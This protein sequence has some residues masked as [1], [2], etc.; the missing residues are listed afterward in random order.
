MQYGIQK[1]KK[2]SKIQESRDIKIINRVA[3]SETS[4][5]CSY[6]LVESS[7]DQDPYPDCIRIQDG[8]M[9]HK[10]RKTLIN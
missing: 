4:T 3:D 9:T 7:V 2:I 5:P 6:K 1:Y 10:N 8:K